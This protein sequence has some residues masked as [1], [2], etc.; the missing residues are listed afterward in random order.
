MQ[1]CWIYIIVLNDAYVYA[2]LCS[3]LAATIRNSVVIGQKM[4]L[5]GCHNGNEMR[6]ATC[7]A[8][9]TSKVPTQVNLL[10]F[11]ILWLDIT[12]IIFVTKNF[13]K[14]FY[15]PWSH[16]L[17]NYALNFRPNCT[18]LSSITVS[19]IASCIR[20]CQKYCD[21][22]PNQ[23]HLEKCFTYLNYMPQQFTRC[24]SDIEKDA[25]KTPF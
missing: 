12:K 8:A 21:Y 25:N 17:T 14:T 20:H 6:N 19:F 18:S 10:L 7:V 13:L 24:I 3:L 16:T 4:Q 9:K 15:I 11:P 2:D 23:K 1:Y 22:C 5:T